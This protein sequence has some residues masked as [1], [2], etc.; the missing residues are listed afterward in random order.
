VVQDDGRRLVMRRRLAG[1]EPLA[2]LR[3]LADEDGGL[4]ARA[5]AA[6]L[7]QPL[8]TSG[9]TKREAFRAFIDG[10]GNPAL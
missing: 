1:E 10:G 3:K 8:P 4:L 7:G 5:L 6:R 9:Y 2:A